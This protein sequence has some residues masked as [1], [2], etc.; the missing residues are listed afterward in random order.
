MITLFG[1]LF[2]IIVVYQ[3][4][5]EMIEVAGESAKDEG[6]IEEHTNNASLGTQ[7]GSS[8]PGSSE[9]STLSS[10]T[11]TSKSNSN[12]AI[13]RSAARKR[14]K[15]ASRKAETVIE[16]CRSGGDWRE[17]ATA[18]FLLA[19]SMEKMFFSD[20]YFGKG[21]QLD[22]YSTALEAAE[23]AW[24]NLMSLQ[25]DQ[26]VGIDDQGLTPDQIERDYRRTM[27][28]SALIIA[29]CA[30]GLVG[31]SRQESARTI[32]QTSVNPSAVQSWG[33]FKKLLE[34]ECE[35]YGAH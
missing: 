24:G 8:I 17:A 9:T 10:N 7:P 22:S 30:G 1:W 2:I 19:D 32:F 3:F 4:L 29:W 23:D 16:E 15:D 18:S 21:S 5:T 26:T 14:V 31:E 28:A 11:A 33:S 35:K 34:K 6:T 13:D 20:Q 12:S 27:V 25:A